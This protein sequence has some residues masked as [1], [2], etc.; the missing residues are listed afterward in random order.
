[1]RSVFIAALGLALAGCVTTGSSGGIKPLGGD[2][3]MVS[4][5][6][7]FTNVVERAAVFCNSYGQTVE[8]TGNTTQ[9]GLASGRDYAVLVFRCVS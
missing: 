3:Y 8:V 2:T 5:M 4:E 6:S 7:G 1:M 9:Q